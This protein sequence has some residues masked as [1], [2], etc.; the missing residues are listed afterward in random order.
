MQYFDTGYDTDEA[1][2]NVDFYDREYEEPINSQNID[3][4]SQ[5]ET[6]APQPKYEQAPTAS[7]VAEFSIANAINLRGKLIVTLN[8]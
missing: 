6:E 3:I 4:L 8:P 5:L 1:V 2:P 7:S